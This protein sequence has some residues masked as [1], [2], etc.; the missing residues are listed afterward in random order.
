MIMKDIKIKLKDISKKLSFTQI[1]VI[2]G[3]SDTKEK[4]M[5]EV[6]NW[7]G[8]HLIAFV[9][10]EE[11]YDSPLLSKSVFY[12]KD[13][14]WRPEV[15]L[16]ALQVEHEFG[17][18]TLLSQIEDHVKKAY[19][20]AKVIKKSVKKKVKDW[21]IPSNIKSD[22]SNYMSKFFNDRKESRFDEFSS[23]NV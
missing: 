15:G 1:W 10:F 11:N 20:N 23:R 2:D 12:K 6:R 13:F 3:Y 14:S 21:E 7:F 9:A 5:I 17:A 4:R 8:Y 22:V 16:I 18:G 19:T